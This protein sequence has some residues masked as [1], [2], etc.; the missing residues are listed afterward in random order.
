MFGQTG[1]GC[2]VCCNVQEVVGTMR[3]EPMSLR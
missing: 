2:D 3:Y 1:K